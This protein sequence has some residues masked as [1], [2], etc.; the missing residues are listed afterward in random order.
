MRSALRLIRGSCCGVVFLVGF[1]SPAAGRP[2]ELAAADWLPPTPA[3]GKRFRVAVGDPLHFALMATT[4]EAPEA[5]VSI[6]A[7]GVPAGA[8]FRTTAGNPAGATVS[9]RPTSLQAGRTFSVTFTADPNHPDIAPATRH[10]A[11]EVARAAARAFTLSNNATETYRYAFVMRRV[12]ARNA[13]DRDARPVAR[14]ALLTPERTTNLVLTLEGRRTSNDTWIHVRLPI[15]PNNTT[16][17][18]PRGSLSDWK[19][20]RTRLVADRRSLTATL[21]RV[22]KPVFS[23]QIGIGRPQWP[24]PVGEFYVRNQL[25]GFNDPFYG[26][27]AWGTNA[28]S[29]VLTDWPGGGF[30]GIHGTNEPREIPGRVSH[31]CIRMKNRD[32]LRLARLMP[33]GTPLT[34]R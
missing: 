32:I 27:I 7:S 17:W 11:I 29:P 28:R 6:D 2:D 26:P 19:I 16:G 34:V 30:I 25:Y 4:R 23:A 5:T 8:T 13:P 15:L 20:V 21:Y 3:E 18:V 24:T 1:A 9:W 10:V 31:G 14:L 12:V 33:V 22:G